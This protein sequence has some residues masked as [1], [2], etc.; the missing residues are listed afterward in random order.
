VQFNGR[1]HVASFEANHP[2]AGHD[3]DFALRNF[4]SNLQ[5]AGRGREVLLQT[6]TLVSKK[7]RPFIAGSRNSSRLNFHPRELPLEALD[8]RS[9]SAAVASPAV[10][11][12]KRSRYSRTRLF[13][14]VPITS[15]RHRASCITSSSMDRVTFMSTY[16]VYVESGSRHTGVL[17]RG[18]IAHLLPGR[19]LL[20]RHACIVDGPRLDRPCGQRGGGD[21][22]QQRQDE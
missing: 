4:G 20:V 2:R 3:L 21:G 7:A 13:T 6:R 10:F 9:N 16:N 12:A 5:F 14:L 22:Y 18:K 11:P 19:D 17:L 1:D 15:A 8:R